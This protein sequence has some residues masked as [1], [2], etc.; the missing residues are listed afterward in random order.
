MNERIKKIRE[1][2]G[3]NMREFGQRIGSDAAAISRYE[4]GSRTPSNAVLLSIAREF[5]VRIEWLKTGE[6]EMKDPILTDETPALMLRTYKN[7]PE[8]LKELVQAMVKMDPEW[9]KKLD[10]ALEEVEKMK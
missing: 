10:A 3:L 8:R 6:G 1:E 4:S 9:W 7:M 2:H 5:G